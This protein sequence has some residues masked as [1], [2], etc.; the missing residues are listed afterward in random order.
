MEF[1]FFSHY[2]C[3]LYYLSIFIKTLHSKHIWWLS[4]FNYHHKIWKMGN[5]Q[6]CRFSI[7]ITNISLLQVDYRNRHP[8]SSWSS[9]LD[10]YQNAR[11]PCTFL[12]SKYSKILPLPRQKDKI[13]SKFKV[14]FFF[15]A[16]VM[17]FIYKTH[18]WHSYLHQWCSYPK[19]CKSKFHSEVKEIINPLLLCY[20]FYISI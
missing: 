11:F 17:R 6:H 9:I 8:Y 1:H 20:S 7:E 18:Q 13:T 2:Q 10:L 5:F 14:R 19:I 15:F 16:P 12:L 4:T 3:I